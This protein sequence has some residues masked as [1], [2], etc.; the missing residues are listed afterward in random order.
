MN[1]VRQMWA[2]VRLMA[3]FTVVLGLLYPLAG[4]AFGKVLS[5]SG[6]G[7]LVEVD[8]VVVGSSL[9]GQSFDGDQWFIPRPSAVDYD[10]MASGGSNLGP[11]TPASSSNMVSAVSLGQS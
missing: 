1:I 6:N 7:S 8:G 2:G 3:V 10:A 4:V 11:N 5:D 9:L